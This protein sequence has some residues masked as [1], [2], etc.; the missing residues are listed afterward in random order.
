MEGTSESWRLITTEKYT[1]ILTAMTRLHN[2]EPS[3]LL[4]SVY[5]QIYK[6]CKNYAL[7]A[8]GETFF[9]VAHPDDVIGVAIVDE[10]VDI[11]T[12]KRIIYIEAAY[13]EI[14]RAH[15]QDHTKGRTLY[16]K[17]AAPATMTTSGLEVLEKS[18]SGTGPSGTV[19]RK[20]RFSHYS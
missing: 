20:Q 3:K 11:D 17:H 19:P 15:G 1:A 5:P 18:H 2:G 13:T 16:L 7:I 8:S 12:V 14:K 4:R 10:T 6:W 9:V